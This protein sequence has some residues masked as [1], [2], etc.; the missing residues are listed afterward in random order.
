MATGEDQ[1]VKCVECGEEFLFTAGEQEFYRTHG[2]THAPTRCKRCRESRKPQRAEGREH[3]P[4]GAGGREKTMYPAVC[5]ECG[6]ATQVPFPPTS[7]RPIYCRDCF[8]SKKPARAGGTARAPA[9]RGAPASPGAPT[10][11]RPQGAVKW[12]NEAKGFGF[13][14]D[15]TGEDIFVH[16]SAIHADGFKTLQPGD[17]VEY[18]VVP[19]AKG[20]Q[21]ANVVR[22]G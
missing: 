12:F 18:D 21:A 4:A 5:S 9:P 22:I 13:I 19:G 2:L 17:R 15:D 8:Q 7:G 3:R 1:R 14:Q 20:K 10:G 6:T 11:G 16:F